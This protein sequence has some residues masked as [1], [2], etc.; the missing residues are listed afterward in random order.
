MVRS[1]IQSQTSWSVKRA[2]GSFTTKKKTK[3]KTKKKSSGDDRIP[4]E[5]FKIP[6]DDAVKVLH[7]IC[8]QTWKTQQ[9]PQNWKTYVFIPIP[10]KV[11]AKGCSELFHMLIRLCLKYFNLG[12]SSMWTKN[13]QMYK[14]G[15]EEAEEPEI[16]SPTFIGSWRKQGNSRK[17]HLLLLHWIH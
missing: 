12:F 11:S 14:L 17:K 10:K 13:F 16:K 6:K 7:S 5:L 4:A 1:L 3:T 2:L 9:W 15:F 8:Q